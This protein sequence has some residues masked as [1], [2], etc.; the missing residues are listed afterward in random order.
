[1]SIDGAVANIHLDVSIFAIARLI[2]SE[3]G[4]PV[5]SDMRLSLAN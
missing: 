5:S 2:N 1:M 4:A 3:I